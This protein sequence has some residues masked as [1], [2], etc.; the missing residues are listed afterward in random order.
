MCRLYAGIPLVK[1]KNEQKYTTVIRA[2]FRMSGFLSL[3]H[4]SLGMAKP[5]QISPPETGMLGIPSFQ[6]T[7]EC[8]SCFCLQMPREPQT[9]SKHKGAR[10]EEH[11]KSTESIQV[12][13]NM[14][15]RFLWMVLWLVAGTPVADMQGRFL[16]ILTAIYRVSLCLSFSE[17]LQN[18][19]I[20]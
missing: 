4:Q 15:S 11:W 7:P 16:Y 20:S 8:F 13:A 14:S 9:Y 10:G 17:V 12:S 5:L 6:G 19:A 3:L 2:I 1:G 18:Q